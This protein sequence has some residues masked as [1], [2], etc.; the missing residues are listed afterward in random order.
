MEALHT[1]LRPHGTPRLVRKGSNILFQGEI[2]RHVNIIRDGVV[3]EY[4]IDSSGEERIV[5]L[6]GKGDI[7]PLSWTL[8][9]TSNTL[10]YYDALIDTRLM[11][12]TKQQFLDI[13][14]EDR[15]I[16][17]GLLQF[18]S[19]EYTALLLR[20]T[21]LEQS[22]AVEKIAFTLYYLLFRYGNESSPGK[23]T[24][25]VKMSQ[26]MIASFVGLT[27][28][29]TTKNLKVL[30]DKGIIDYSRSI[31]T[32]NKTKLEAFMGEDSFRDMVVN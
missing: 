28:E 29:S 10:F 6:Y 19:N 32:I 31:Y 9:E 12:V 16:L 26:A 1:R 30:K 21:G 17:S 8:G 24:I 20:A 2:P 13:V 22:R 25:D 4:T 3:R 14:M 15:A 23:Y 18:V 5:A 11:C 7:F 27:R